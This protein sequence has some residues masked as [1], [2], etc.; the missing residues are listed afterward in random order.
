MTAAGPRAARLACA[1]LGGY[2]SLGI[3]SM[4]AIGVDFHEAEKALMLLALPVFLVLFLLA[5]ASARPKRFVSALAGGAALMLGAA[6]ALQR[7][8]LS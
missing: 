7:T 8:G 4:V 3:A 6:W 5:F 2:L 1:L